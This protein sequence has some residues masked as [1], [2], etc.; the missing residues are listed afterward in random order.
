MQLCIIK[1]YI[2][3]TKGSKGNV[4]VPQNRW[5]VRHNGFRSAKIKVGI[6]NIVV[7]IPF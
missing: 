4:V 3:G 6:T 7:Y 2:K 1:I 5:H